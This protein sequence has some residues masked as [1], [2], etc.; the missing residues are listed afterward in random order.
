MMK[1]SNVGRFDLIAVA[2]P[3][4]G[5]VVLCVV[6][7]QG[8]SHDGQRWAL[9]RPGRVQ[10]PHKEGR[11]TGACGRRGGGGDFHSYHDYES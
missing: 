9:P 3:R 10:E 1:S 8:R 6:E 4:F 7:L 2:N 11:G 5:V